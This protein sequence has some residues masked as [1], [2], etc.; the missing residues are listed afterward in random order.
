MKI[1]YSILGI[2]NQSVAGTGIKNPS[3]IKYLKSKIIPVVD[4]IIKLSIGGIR[5]SGT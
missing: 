1:N 4:H 5:D 2:R 3:K